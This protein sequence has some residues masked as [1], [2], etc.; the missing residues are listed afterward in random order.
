MRIELEAQ[1]KALQF[2][3]EEKSEKCNETIRVVEEKKGVLMA[4]ANVKFSTKNEEMSEFSE[5]VN[6]VTE[7]GGKMRKM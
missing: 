2:S 3:I 1:E 5:Q 6:K 7:W 4:S